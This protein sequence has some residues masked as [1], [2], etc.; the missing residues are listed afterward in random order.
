MR[1]KN[2]TVSK[3]ILILLIMVSCISMFFSSLVHATPINLDESQPFGYDVVSRPFTKYINRQLSLVSISPTVDFSLIE[4]HIRYPQVT[5]IVRGTSHHDY[6][7]NAC[8]GI[9]NLSI[10]YYYQGVLPLVMNSASVYAQKTPSQYVV[11]YN[12]NFVADYNRGGL[13]FNLNFGN[14]RGSFGFSR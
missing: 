7:T 11:Y 1:S 10:S 2:R 6:Y 13:I 12:V 9:S 14:T 5:I 3:K 8:V 4:N